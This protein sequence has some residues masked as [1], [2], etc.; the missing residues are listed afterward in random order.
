MTMTD[1]DLAAIEARADAA[2][3]GPWKNDLDKF[4]D[5]EDIQA[6]VCNEGI[7]LL[8]TIATGTETDWQEAGRSQAVKDAAFISAA[9]SDVPALLAEVH[10]LRAAR[11]TVVEALGPAP[12]HCC[13]GCNEE[14]HQALTA[15]KEALGQP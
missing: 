8:A 7:D 5:G 6:C 9:R 10:R 12:L 4:T 1:A 2:T 3:A 11:Q 13:A 14:M 15:A